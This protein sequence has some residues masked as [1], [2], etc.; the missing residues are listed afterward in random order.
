MKKLIIEC[1]HCDSEIEI[2]PSSEDL[3]EFEA[4]VLKAGKEIKSGDPEP[5]PEPKPDPKPEP[6]PKESNWLDAVFG[7]G[8]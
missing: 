5:E 8:K 6:K 3:T 4:A 7:G 2:S 1:P